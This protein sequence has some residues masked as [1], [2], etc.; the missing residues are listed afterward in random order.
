MQ[1]RSNQLPPNSWTDHYPGYKHPDPL[2]HFLLLFVNPGEIH[3]ELSQV[4]TIVFFS[5]VSFCLLQVHCSWYF[6]CLH[7]TTWRVLS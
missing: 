4:S 5:I 3:G 1:A 2:H 6:Q 7:F